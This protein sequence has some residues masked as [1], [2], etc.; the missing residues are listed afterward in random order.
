MEPTIAEY[1]MK[2]FRKNPGTAV[3]MVIFTFGTLTTVFAQPTPIPAAVSPRSIDPKRELVITDLSVIE[4]PKL[5]D[6]TSDTPYW[7]FK[8]LMEQMSVNQNTSEFVQAWLEQWLV[9]QPVGFGNSAARPSMQERVIG[10]WLEAS[11]GSELDLNL[12]PFKLLAIVNRM[13]L[14]SF[15]CDE[16]FS[17]GEGRFVFA[18]LD[19]NGRQLGG[20]FTA[21][22]EYNLKAT[23]F[24]ELQEWALKWHDLGQSP[25]GSDNYIKKLATITRKFTDAYLDF[26]STPAARPTFNSHLNQL[27]TNE[28]GLA[29]PWELREFTID[30]HSDSLLQTLSRSL[31]PTASSSLLQTPVAQTPDFEFF[32]GSPLGR[33]IMGVVV[34]SG[35][36][37]PPRI[38]GSAAPTPF[39]EAWEPENVSSQSRH[40]FAVNTCNG[41]HR[42]ETNT[43]FVHIGIPSNNNLPASLGNPAFL[44]GF[45]T[46]IDVQ[47]PV[48]PTITRTF[49]DIKRRRLDFAELLSYL[50]QGLPGPCDQPMPL[51]RVH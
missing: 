47:D 20:G 49:N 5:T 37:I 42:I 43:P 13:D 19:E 21:I 39:G 36:E 35:M 41:C 6:P 40:E 10:P 7:T 33:T 38:L 8:Y 14:R 51:K 32:N 46:G 31:L 45:M 12:A 15:D 18:V 22:F 34:N 27:R 1:F 29:S 4:H 50:A 9:D 24:N 44:S 30:P 2:P 28:I 11:G 23:N 26:S 17:A 16:I 25:I 3:V 48:D